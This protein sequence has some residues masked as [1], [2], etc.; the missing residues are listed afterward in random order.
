MLIQ[1]H[2]FQNREFEF[3]KQIQLQKDQ[4]ILL[5]TQIEKQ[6]KTEEDLNVHVL[7]LNEQILSL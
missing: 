7:Q 4:N 3:R 5:R 6:A 2:D 1:I